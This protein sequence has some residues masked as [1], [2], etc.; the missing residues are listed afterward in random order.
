MVAEVTRGTDD[1]GLAMHRVMFDADETDFDE[2]QWR[3]DPETPTR[4]YVLGKPTGDDETF[5][6][7]FERED[8]QL[9]AATVRTPDGRGDPSE[10]PQ[11]VL[12]FVMKAGYAPIPDSG[13][14]KESW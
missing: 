8:M 11:A 2:M 4:F 1:N 9:T 7:V 5:Q 14:D 3:R 12:D 10:L 6:W 13:L